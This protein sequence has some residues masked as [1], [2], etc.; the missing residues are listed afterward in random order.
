MSHHF[1]NWIILHASTQ[2]IKQS[3][4]ILNNKNASRPP[5]AQLKVHDFWLSEFS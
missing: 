5:F 3:I 4:F 1:K 2:I